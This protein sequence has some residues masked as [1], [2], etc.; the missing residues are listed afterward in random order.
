MKFE[1]YFYNTP[2]I[3]KNQG[4]LY[5]IYQQNKDVLDVNKIV[6][7]YYP[8][9]KMVKNSLGRIDFKFDF[10][11]YCKDLKKENR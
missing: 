2:A 7:K 1:K 5:E 9:A 3:G 4:G 6:Q 10:K 11:S 8:Y